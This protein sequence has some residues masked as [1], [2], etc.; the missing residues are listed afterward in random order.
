[1]AIVVSGGAVQLALTPRLAVGRDWQAS[2]PSHHDLYRETIDNIHKA[3]AYVNNHPAH[4]AE[5]LL[6]LM[7]PSKD[8]AIFMNI[9]G[10]NKPILEYPGPPTN[11]TK[12]EH[13]WTSDRYLV[14]RHVDGGMA[15]LVATIDRTMVWFM[16]PPTPANLKGGDEHMVMV[17]TD[18]SKVIYIPGG[19]I[20]STLTLKGGF[21]SGISFLDKHCIRAAF[22][23]FFYSLENS[24]FLD[25][26]LDTLH[27]ILELTMKDGAIAKWQ[28]HG[29]DLRRRLTDQNQADGKKWRKYGGDKAW[30]KIADLMRRHGVE[31]V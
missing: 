28:A 26:D 11:C 8:T 1:M 14:E 3:Q 22:P 29:N 6:R 9:Q 27:D 25:H 4:P 15:G 20:H 19:C 17:V 21:I 7:H 10:I 12:R 24:P 16:A 2:R 31:L 18:P 13:N 5:T 23:S 30:R